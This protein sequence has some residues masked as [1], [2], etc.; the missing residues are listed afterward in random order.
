VKEGEPRGL[1]L[2]ESPAE[3]SRDRDL[4][5]KDGVT[6]YDKVKLTEAKAAKL[7]ARVL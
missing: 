7:R 4:R 3:T 2:R 1:G 6:R 5:N